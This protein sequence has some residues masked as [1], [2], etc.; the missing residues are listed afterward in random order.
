MNRE[1]IKKKMTTPFDTNLYN[2]NLDMVRRR[3]PLVY[4]EIENREFQFSYPLEFVLDRANQP[5]AIITIAGKERIA[6]YEYD[7]IQRD[8]SSG[9]EDWDL[10]VNDFLFCI[11]FGLG[12]LPL[13]ASQNFSGGPHIV[14]VEPNVEMFDLALRLIDLR[15]LLKYEKLAIFVGNQEPVKEIVSA[16]TAQLPLGKTQVASFGP[17]RLIYGDAFKIF[18]KEVID[19]IRVVRNIDYTARRAGKMIFSNAMVNLPSLF[20]GPD[21]GALKGTFDGHPAVCVAAGPSLDKDIPFLKT[22]GNRALILCA[23]SAAHALVGAGIIPHVVVTTDMNPINF[24]KLRN[25]LYQ[26]RDTILI[27]SIEANP[28]CVG[29]F[30][31]S[32]RIAV[33]AQNAL[34]N[35][36]FGPEWGL[37]WNLPAMTSVSHTALFTA[38]A[39]GAAPIVMVGMDFAYSSGKSHASGSVFRYGENKNAMITVEGVRGVPVLSLPQLITDRKQIENGIV[40]APGRFIDSSLDGALIHGTQIKSLNE[41]IDTHFHEDSDVFEILQNIEWSAPV[42]DQRILHVLEQMILK[43]VGFCDTCRKMNRRC[44]VD[45]QGNKKTKRKQSRR[46]EQIIKQTVVFDKRYD[47]IL[48]VLNMLRYEEVASLNR[49]M[50]ELK[51]LNKA[52]GIRLETIAKAL[53]VYEDYFKSLKEAGNVFLAKLTDTVKLFTNKQELKHNMPPYSCGEKSLHTLL[54]LYLS[55]GE[56]WQVERLLDEYESHLPVSLNTRLLV[57]QKYADKRMWL[58]AL[59][60]LQRL[61]V[62]FPDDSEVD[63]LEAKIVRSIEA[64]FIKA[65]AAWQTGAFEETRRALIELLSVYPEHLAALELKEKLKFKDRAK[66]ARLSPDDA[67]IVSTEHRKVLEQKSIHLRNQ[68]E[69][70]RAIG[71]LEGLADSK[72]E[73]AAAIR[74]MIGDVRFEQKDYLSAAWHYQRALKK[75]SGNQEL[76]VKLKKT[77]HH[78]DSVKQQYIEGIAA[79]DADLSNLKHNDSRPDSAEEM[80]CKVQPFVE[81]ERYAAAITALEQLLSVYPDFSVAHNDLGVLFLREGENEKARQHYVKASQLAPENVTF[82]KNLADFNYVV[83]GNVQEALEIYVRLLRENPNDKEILLTLGHICVAQEKKDDAVT[84]YKKVLEI[85]PDHDEAKTCLGV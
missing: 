45:S 30:L 52:N 63:A 27:F 37:D 57:I 28:E 77:N 2:T 24:E 46:L 41:I 38:A 3:F 54:S 5:N 7:D 85:D 12:Y 32:K 4:A 50:S 10:S 68:G 69:F 8:V 70:D 43:V 79:L 22:I 65:L 25:D 67:A 78:I 20:A 60:H 17:S 9:I 58:P 44:H 1:R 26:L 23:D 47:R 11:G 39:L 40:K 66:A 48:R 62:D 83:L 19:N 13:A 76:Q 18:E 29:S 72:I 51:N 49:R 6:L 31:S 14:V 80:Y 64:I 56:L 59:N 82:Q 34:L 36:W 53:G 33:T 71:I 55:K 61:K 84:F 35:H 74:E 15:K 21:L 42:Q 75:S 16:Y 73:D 81:Q